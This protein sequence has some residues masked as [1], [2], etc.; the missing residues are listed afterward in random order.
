MT[1]ISEWSVTAGSVAEYRAAFARY[2]GIVRAAMPQVIIVWSPNDGTDTDLAVTAMYPGDDVVD[3]LAPDSYDWTPG[4]W[5][6]EQ[7]GAYI[8]RGSAADPSGVESWRLFAFEHGT[9][10]GCPSGGG[11]GGRAAAG[12]I[13]RTS[14]RCTPG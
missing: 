3:A 9:A 10:L 8:A 5:D 2:A 12:T 4:S 7:V 14:P 13:R 1:G 6:V 11:V